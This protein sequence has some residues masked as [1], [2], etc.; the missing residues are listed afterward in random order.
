MTGSRSGQSGSRREGAAEA[1]RAI[2]KRKELAP[3]RPP[4]R[5]LSL[6]AAMW[7]EYRIFKAAGLEKEWRR[8]WAAYL[9]EIPAPKVA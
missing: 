8:R 4:G 1:F 7:E 3:V 5:G 2:G 9:M 6:S